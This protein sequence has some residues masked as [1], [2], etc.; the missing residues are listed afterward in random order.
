MIYLIIILELKTDVYFIGRYYK[1]SSINHL[2]NR[3]LRLSVVVPVA[4]NLL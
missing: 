3:G 1:T 4:G 2:M